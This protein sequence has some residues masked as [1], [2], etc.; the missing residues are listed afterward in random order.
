MIKMEKTIAI[1]KVSS[2]LTVHI[3]VEI[4]TDLVITDGD[5]IVWKTVNGKVVIEKLS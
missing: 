5:K 3:P 4:A 1:T 2:K